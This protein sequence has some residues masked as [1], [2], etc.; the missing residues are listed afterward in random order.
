[1]PETS[2]FPSPNDFT[3]A[4]ASSIYGLRQII[5]SN[6]ETSLNNILFKGGQFSSPRLAMKS[7]FKPGNPTSRHGHTIAP[8]VLFPDNPEYTRLP[9]RGFS[10]P[11]P[12]EF[13]N[14]QCIQNLRK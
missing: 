13:I 4:P 10:S 9:G 8:V 2:V 5:L 14:F 7:N 1:M 11:P 6:W 3:N 12:P